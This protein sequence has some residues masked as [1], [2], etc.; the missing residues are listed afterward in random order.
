MASFSNNDN[1]SGSINI[2]KLTADGFHYDDWAYKMSLALKMKDLWEYVEH[3]TRGESEA[4]SAATS[5]E[6]QKNDQK[7]LAIIVFALSD[8]L[9]SLVRSLDTSKAVWDTLAARFNDTSIANMIFVRRKFLNITMSNTDTMAAH[10]SNVK[11]VYDKL[12]SIGGRVDETDHCI[13]LLQSLT[14]TYDNVVIT[15]TTGRE[16]KDLTYTLVT[17]TLL[18]EEQRRA[19]QGV[20]RAAQEGA[21]YG[22]AGGDRGPRSNGG[23]NGKQCTFCKKTGHLEADCYSKNGFP[24]GHSRYNGSIKCAYCKR[25]GHLES[26]C[27][28]KKRDI[29]GAAALAAHTE[30]ANIAGAKGTTASPKP[31]EEYMLC[32]HCGDVEHAN[33][34]QLSDNKDWIID[35]GATSHMTASKTDMMNYQKLTFPIEVKGISD[36]LMAVGKG[37]IA[38]TTCKADGTITQLTLTG[39]LHV[40]HIRASLISVPKLVACGAAVNFSSAGCTITLDGKV[41]ADGAPI[42]NVGNKL[43]KLRLE[44]SG[45]PPD[46]AA[47]AARTAA[48]PIAPSTPSS[49]LA[50]VERRTACDRLHRSLGHLSAG[51]ME[52]L[53]KG[54]MIDG[55]SAS[56]LLI[57]GKIELSHCDACEVGK[58]SRAPFLRS[59]VGTR[60]TH[61]NELVH[62]DVGGP[63]PVPSLGGHKYYVTFTD[64]FT[65]HLHVDFMKT[66]DEV[67]SYTKKYKAAAE[68]AHPGQPLQRFRSDNGGEYGSK[69]FAQFLEA[70]GVR[71]EFTTAY[72]PEQNG[73]AESANRVLFNKAR[74]MMADAG[75]LDDDRGK[76]FWA[77][78]VHT[79]AFL[80]EIS[81]TNVLTDGGAPALITPYE[82]WTGRRPDVARLRRFGCLAYVHV[83]AHKRT[84]LDPRAVKMIFVGYADN[85]KAYRCFNPVTKKVIISRNVTFNEQANG[86]DMLTKGADI[87]GN[88]LSSVGGQPD[89]VVI[90]DTDDDEPPHDLHS[91]SSDDS[92]DDLDRVPPPV[93]PAGVPP[94]V[95][96]VVAPVPAADDAG[97]EGGRPQRRRRA[98]VPYW[99]VEASRRA[100][101]EYGNV[102]GLNTYS[103]QH[104]LDNDPDT[105]EEATHVDNPRK[106]N[107]WKAMKFEVSGFNDLG[108]KRVVKLPPGRKPIKSKWVYTTKR[109]SDGVPKINPE[110]GIAEKARVTARGDMEV[111]GIDYKE[112]FSPVAK[113]VTFR[114]L[115]AVAAHLDLDLDHLDVSQA[116]L[117]GDLDEEIYMHPP[118]GFELEDGYVWQLLKAVYGLKQ[119]SR[120]FSIKLTNIL[121]TLGFVQ[122]Q[123]DPCLFSRREADGSHTFIL[124]WVDDEIVASRKGTDMAA[125]VRREM[126]RFFKMKGDEL[127]FF[128]GIKIERNRFEKTLI[129]TQSAAI[130]DIIDEFKLTD[131][132]IVATPMAPGSKLTKDMA[133]S[134]PDDVDG[135]KNVPYRSLVMKLNY[136]ATT[137]RPDIAHSVGELTKFLNNPGRAHWEAAKHT[138]RYLKGTINLGITFDGKLPLHLE[139]YSDADWAGDIDSRK[140]TTGYVFLLAG[141]PISWSSKRQP[142]VA[143][144]T[145]EAEFM[146]VCAATQEALFLKQLLADINQNEAVGA[147]GII[148]HEDNQG[149]LAYTKDPKFHGRAKHIDIKWHF[150]RD[151]LKKGT[152]KIVY[153]NTSDQIADLLTKGVPKA[154]FLRLIKLMGMRLTA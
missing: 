55:I 48:P 98:P 21:L 64:D 5:K 38:L 136:L 95:A 20:Q 139:G 100:T 73:I 138:V 140:S 11:N 133:P 91:S 124:I 114:T 115:L 88:G 51:E 79:A 8:D 9:M 18:H 119:A 35:S 92:D 85:H 106:D 121:I 132:K 15:L 102:A 111:H 143:L 97:A 3:G 28:T 153:I 65:K 57:N 52:K 87:T 1:N 152:I 45:S 69:A 66:K 148:I 53:V 22:G 16:I 12:K 17:T 110:T 61:V 24:P 141:A 46:A 54:G 39:V 60:A 62:S 7:A 135:M 99:D 82:A 23:R 116:F 4:A 26:A 134:T 118:K 129:V 83:E 42:S 150:V 32:A 126:E 34:S 112:T 71:H 113:H 125:K 93:A 14:D 101:A 31:H 127:N 122:S 128:I 37:D 147:D 33:L 84:K 13:V 80:R 41:I 142:T 154:Q 81:P 145:M 40:P 123:V 77:H 25:S 2:T 144:S 43:Y 89:H 6:H 72:T 86:I 94:P 19:E 36:K 151:E 120:A 76:A 27:H 103:E 108:T 44:V 56:K 74:A 59:V 29:Q 10:I 96:P 130:R 49:T 78:A 67:L 104:F 146:A 30:Q 137:T 50:D 68:T 70:D 58:H 107:W 105:Y 47:H 75:M 149:C 131:A 90:S 63:L 109:D 117:Y